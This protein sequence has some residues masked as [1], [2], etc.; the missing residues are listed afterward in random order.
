M[1]HPDPAEG[2]D[3]ALIE[4]PPK[5]TSKRTRSLRIKE[6]R[7]RVSWVEKPETVGGYRVVS[8]RRYRAVTLVASCL[9]I[10]RIARAL[11]ASGWTHVR[12]WEQADTLP[13]DWPDRRQGLSGECRIVYVEGLR[14]GDASLWPAWWPEGRFAPSVIALSVFF[15]D[16]RSPENEGSG[17][18]RTGGTAPS[19]PSWKPL[20]TAVLALF[21]ARSVRGKRP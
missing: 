15:E 9:S 11:A 18:A 20:F 16:G 2:A 14:V 3:A 4:S 12:L 1:H 5:G 10:D 7:V 17:N 8:Q 19:G 13:E 6:R 21:M